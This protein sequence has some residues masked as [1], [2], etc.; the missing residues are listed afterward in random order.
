[1]SVSAGE[2]VAIRGHREAG[3]CVD[4]PEEGVKV[5]SPPKARAVSLDAVSI[6]GATVRLSAR[7]SVNPCE[8]A[9]HRWTLR[10]MAFLWV[11]WRRW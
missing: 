1:M 11:R 4:V 9:L 6:R 10:S 5:A 3:E 8:Q 7:A 2:L